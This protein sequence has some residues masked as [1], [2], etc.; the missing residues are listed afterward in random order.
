MYKARHLIIVLIS[1]TFAI[2]CV[3]DSACYNNADCPDNQ[4]CEIAIGKSTGQCRDMCGEDQDCPDGYLCDLS[5]KKCMKA[6]CSSDAECPSD[7]ECVKGRCVAMKPI[8]C[9]EG[10]VSIENLFCIDRYE[11]SRPDATKDSAGED[12]SM[13]TSRPG[14]IPWQVLDNAEALEACKAAGKTLCTESEWNQ[15]C[16]GPSGTVYGYGD[17]YDPTICNSID[18]Y[19]LCDSTG[20]CADREPCPF[21]HCYN[22]CYALF[23]LEPTGYFNDC[24]NAYGVFDMN[25]NLWE[26]VQG[27]DDTRIRGGAYNCMDS[28]RLH[29][30]DYIPGNWKPSAQGFR[31]CSPGIVKADAGAD[32]APDGGASR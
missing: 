29:R 32:D 11:A 21:P 20:P 12:G 6:E 15:A 25:G 1:S 18:T 10:A 27:G 26:H 13:A 9:P 7:S 3:V 17:E 2:S 22:E 19:C 23:R 28:E 30:C 24:K 5:Q 16:S 14:V 8:I 4:I 31:C